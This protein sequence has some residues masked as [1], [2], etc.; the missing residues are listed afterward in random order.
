MKMKKIIIFALMLMVAQGA[1]SRLNFR[2]LS[3]KPVEGPW[4]YEEAN[5][6]THSAKIVKNCRYKDMNGGTWWWRYHDEDHGDHEPVDQFH[7]GDGVGFLQCSKSVSGQIFAVFSTY[8]H[9]ETVP[10]YTCKELIWKFRFKG[11]TSEFPQCQALYAH[12]NYDELKNTPVDMTCD[13]SDGSGAQYLLEYFKIKKGE[14]EESSSDYKKAIRFDNRNGS[15]EQT[16]TWWL[17]LTN[18]IDSKGKYE[19][20]HQWASFK[21]R[22]VTWKTHYYKHITFHEN[23]ESV[24]G[25]MAV[26]EIENSHTLSPNAFTREGYTFAGWATSAEGPVAYVDQALVT[27][28]NNDKGPRDLYAVWETSEQEAADVIKKIGVVE[29]TPECR[30]RIDLAQQVYGNLTQQQQATV[31]NSCLLPIAEHVYA[32][33]GLIEAIGT[34][35]DTPES[36]GK[37]DAAREAYAA[38]T[39]VEKEFVSNY[40]TLTDAEESYAAFLAADLIN[41]L[42]EP[43]EYPGSGDAINAAMEAFANLSDKAKAELTVAQLEKLQ[44]AY[45]TYEI[46]AGKSTIHFID[47]TDR[48]IRKQVVDI[49]YPDAPVISGFTFLYWQIVPESIEP[50]DGTIQIQAVYKSETPTET[51]DVYTNP[52]NPAQK[53]IRNGKVYILKDG[54]TYTITGAE[55]K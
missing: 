39:E 18:T 15:S 33:E 49:I 52:A 14:G 6:H 36:K 55:V 28:T 13:Y 5:S 23:A 44:K 35:E 47:K 21:N 45:E 42:P 4:K 17:M 2:E 51:P 3:K 1:W 46:M 53:L 43:V 12:D 50:S 16:I 54:K 41:T 25:A 38:L 37:I 7:D 19:E 20:A 10:A 30:A 32:A 27:A 29:Y 11:R 34:V 8:K 9:E 26:Q 48:T 24:T 40:S 31:A 22:G